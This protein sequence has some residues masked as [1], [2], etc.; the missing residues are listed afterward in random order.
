MSIL[1]TKHFQDRFESRDVGK[2]VSLS[3][4]VALL[5]SISVQG[6]ESNPN[7]H[8]VPD[9]SEEI[10]VIRHHGLRIFLTKKDND[11]VL[12]SITNG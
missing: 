12:L 9:T 3:E 5:E 10:Y 7:I 4:L 1:L 11:L 8:R 2:Q 6:I